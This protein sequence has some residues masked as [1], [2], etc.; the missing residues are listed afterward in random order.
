LNK[1]RGQAMKVKCSANLRA[2]GQNLMNYS[3]GNKGRLPMFA[4]YTQWIW[5]APNKTRDAMMGV[6]DGDKNMGGG[7]RDVL[8]CPIYADKEIDRFWNFGAPSADGKIDGY[9]ALGYINFIKPVAPSY[10]LSGVPSQLVE[11]EWLTTFRPSIKT[12]F[13]PTKPAEIELMADAV[14][15]QNGLF[16]GMGGQG[17]LHV[18]SHMEKNKPSGGNTLYL[19]GHV[20]WVTFREM[21][22]RW[23]T[24]GGSSMRFYFGTGGAP[25]PVPVGPR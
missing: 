7:V 6:R 9:S 13:A 23:E 25:P 5:D 22:M 1:A 4:A 14:F 2:I 20:S 8:F 3:V 19:D 17:V 18:T 10:L 15:E 11:R 21:K 24:G 16:A 12:K